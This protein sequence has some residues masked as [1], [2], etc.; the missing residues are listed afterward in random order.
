MKNLEAIECGYQR[1]T[2]NINSMW[3]TASTLQLSLRHFSVG[4]SYPDVLY[5]KMEWECEDD[6]NGDVDVSVPSSWI[7]KRIPKHYRRIAKTCQFLMRKV[8]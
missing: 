7:G 1:Q 3:G 5:G 8:L 6:D 4:E 2:P